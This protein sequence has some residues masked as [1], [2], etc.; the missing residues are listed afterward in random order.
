M[1]LFEMMTFAVCPSSMFATAH[2]TVELLNSKQN[3]DHHHLGDVWDDYQATCCANCGKDEEGVSL[4]T[5]KSCMLVKYC[6]ADCQKNHWSKHKTDCKRRAAE[7]R[8]KALFKDPPPKDECSICFLPMPEK[9]ICCASLPMATLLSVPIYDLA[10][11]N[12][13]LVTKSMKEYYSCCGKSICVGCIDSLRKSG[14]SG[15]CPFCKS[16]Q[17]SRTREEKNEDLM[18]R[19]E[20]ND[21]GAMCLMGNHHHLGEEGALQ[22]QV[23]AT[24]LWTRASKLGS[25]SA[26]YNLSYYY[27]GGGNM[28]KAKFHLEEAAMAGH[29]TAICN[30][31][32]TEANSGN[33]ERA[34]KHWLIAASA[35]DYY[36]M[37]LLRIRVETG[38]VSQESI[39]S[40]LEAY[41]NSCAERR[42][43]SRDNYIINN[44]IL[45]ERT[46]PR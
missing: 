13:R 29:E 20:A 2:D 38:Y 19:V 27:Q 42:S 15:K 46:R 25:S 34:V 6:N 40:T 1:F 3:M 30:L 10:M 35:G 21:A 5:C 11:A 16:D 14:N 23:K 18:K 9:L 37:H 12:Q 8:D 22:D 32:A 17:S 44:Y 24:E 28:K 39:D 36:S 33:M 45:Q 26:H 7:L 41:N 31:G 4:K 43:E